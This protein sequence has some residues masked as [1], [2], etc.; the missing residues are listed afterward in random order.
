MPDGGLAVPAR[1]PAGRCVRLAEQ[2]DLD[3]PLD[4]RADELSVGERQR[5]EILRVL[6]RGARVLILDEPTAVLTPGETR[7]LFV[8]LRSLRD[9]GRAL[10]FIS[11]KLAE[12]EEIA[13][14]VTVLRRGRVTARLGS[15]GR[16]D[17]RDSWAA[18]CWGAIS[19]RG[20]AGGGAGRLG[21]PAGAAAAS[22]PGPV[23][24]GS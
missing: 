6:S 1:A 19:R 20:S 22:H 15:R 2:F 17:A 5:A 24:A 14:R 12:V 21:A 13:D 8:S 11:H 18:P 4:R 10:I 3:V 9:S 7:R 16:A 23:G